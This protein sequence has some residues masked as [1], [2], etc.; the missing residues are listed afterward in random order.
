MQDKILGYIP[1][2]EKT[3]IFIPSTGG[4][5]N[6]DE[7]TS[8]KFIEASIKVLSDFSLKLLG[9]RFKDRVAVDTSNMETTIHTNGSMNRVTAKNKER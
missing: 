9:E 7:S 1:A 4:S 3:M 6:P 8:K 5:H 2:K